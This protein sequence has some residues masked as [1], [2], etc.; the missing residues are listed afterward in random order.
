LAETDTCPN[1]AFRIGDHA[2]GLQFHPEVDARMACDWAQ[3]DADFVIGALGPRGPAH[4]IAEAE[5]AVSRM[6]APGDR[7]LDNILEQL[8]TCLSG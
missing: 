7:L 1:Q 5:E 6:R 3:E 2:V 4:L 8:M